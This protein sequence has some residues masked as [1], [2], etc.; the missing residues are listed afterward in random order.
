MPIKYDQHIKRPQEELEYSPDEI[1]ELYNCSQDVNYFMKY[2]KIVNPDRGEIFFEPY[3]YQLDLLKKFQAHRFNVALCSRQSGKTSI[4]AAYVLWYA[5]FNTDKVIGIVSNKE[6]SAKMILARL[7]RMY[8]GLPMWLK[9]GVT[10]YQ[11]TGIQFDNNTK[12]MISATSPDAFRGESINVLVCDEFAFVP[13]NQADAFWMAN[14]PTISASTTAKIIIISTPNGLFNI[15]HRIWAESVAGENTFINTKVS[16]QQV[17][18]R[19]DEWAVEQIRNLGKRQFAQEFAVDFIGS[20]NTVIDEEVLKVLLSSYEEAKEY[21]LNN[22]LSIWEKPEEGAMYCLG[23]DPSKGTGEHWSTIQILKIKSVVPIKLQQ[24]GTFRDNKTDV[25]DFADIIN[26]LSR[27]YNDAFILCENNGEGSP[28]VNRLW[29]EHEN[30]NLINSGSK[31]KNIG[32]RSTGGLRKGTKPKAVLLMKKIIE[33]GSIKLVDQETIKELG[34]YIE[35]NDKFFGKDLADDLVSA[36]Y[37]ACYIFEMK[38]LDED[39]KFVEKKGDDV[40]GILADIEDMVED[41]SWLDETGSL[42]D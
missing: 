42:M 35:E 37:W 19:D 38:V 8:E 36:L 21:S 16:W 13:S 7:K 3:D 6:I 18:G 14:Y 26:R 27:F 28:V 34:S 2:V 32:I 20:I 4:V 5:C 9:P 22:R 30:E 23:C 10:E 24:V 39:Y 11:K 29:W 17:P 1:K 12:I 15:F 40:W 33:D 41:W 25:Y 31:K